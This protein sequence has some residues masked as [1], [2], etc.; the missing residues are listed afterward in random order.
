[1]TSAST[2]GF[3]HPAFTKRRARICPYPG[4]F[5]PIYVAAVE[6]NTRAWKLIATYNRTNKM[7][8][9]IETR[10]ILFFCAHFYQK[11]GFGSLRALI[12]KATN[13]H[14]SFN[15]VG[16]SPITNSLAVT[17]SER[18]YKYATT[19]NCCQNPPAVVSKKAAKTPPKPNN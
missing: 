17:S 6:A 3:V 5:E 4:Y 10:L 8:Q 11:K 13:I 2:G 15:I 9:R 14:S 12:S 16:P 7:I 18:P 19:I 1:M